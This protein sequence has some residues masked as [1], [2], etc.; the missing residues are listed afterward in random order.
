MAVVVA[1]TREGDELGQCAAA[2]EEEVLLRPLA[3]GK[4]AEHLRIRGTERND[5]L[6]AHYV[7]ELPQIE[8]VLLIVLR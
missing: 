3:S 5:F 6:I 8:S 2:R 7:N 1:Q 4:A